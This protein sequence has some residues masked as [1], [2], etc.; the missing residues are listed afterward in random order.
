[1]D[2]LTATRKIRIIWP[3]NRPEVVT[4]ATFAMEGDQE[5]CLEAAMNGFIAKPVKLGDLA[6]VLSRCHPHKNSC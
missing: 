2:Q 3:E 5:M 4:I 1:M 6:A